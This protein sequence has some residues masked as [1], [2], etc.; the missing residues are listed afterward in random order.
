MS[1][2][3]AEDHPDASHSTIIGWVAGIHFSATY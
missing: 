1:L 3:R 2:Y